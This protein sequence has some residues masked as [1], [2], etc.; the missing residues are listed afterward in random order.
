LIA[1]IPLSS[2]KTEE[3]TLKLNH[4]SNL[5]PLWATTKIAMSY[6]EP[7]TYIGNIEKSD[8]LTNQLNNIYG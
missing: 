5:Q 2:A 6:G 4:Y 8:N 1:H 7:E 3:E